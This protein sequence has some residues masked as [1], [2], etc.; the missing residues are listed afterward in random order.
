MG[1]IDD[2]F[3]INTTKGLT[4][5]LIERIKA[6]HIARR[7]MLREKCKAKYLAAHEHW[8]FLAQLSPTDFRNRLPIKFFE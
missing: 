8:K 6:E 4:P 1:L 2:I 5:E 7:P 3:Q